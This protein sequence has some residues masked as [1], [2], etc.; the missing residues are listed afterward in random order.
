LTEQPLELGLAYPKIRLNRAYSGKVAGAAMGD[1]VGPLNYVFT[2]ELGL[3]VNAAYVTK[4]PLLLRGAPGS[5]KSS[6][7]RAI[8]ESQGFQLLVRVINS[9]TKLDDLLWRYDYV[10]RLQ[11]ATEPGRKTLHDNGY[12]EPQALWWALAP[13]SG[14]RRGVSKEKW[15]AAML[16]FDLALSPVPPGRDTMLL[17]DEI[18][19]ADPTL[20]NDLLVAL[21]EGKFT[22]RETGDEIVAERS[23]L[24]IIT[25]NDERE[26]SRAFIRRCIVAELPQLRDDALYEWFLKIGTTH[27]PQKTELVTE[28]ARFLVDKSPEPPSVAELVDLLR[29]CDQLNIDTKHEHFGL[30]RNLVATKLTPSLGG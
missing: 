25:T 10:R 27:F 29:A 3:A 8:A 11:H 22:V 14:E 2:T 9:D 1:A 28:V 5:G 20:P 17:L 6:F 12:V 21:G 19:K 4:R 30:M 23:P 7:A 24:I 16:A 13:E 26:L 18:D 15:G